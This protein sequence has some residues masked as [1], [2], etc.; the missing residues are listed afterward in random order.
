MSFTWR[1]SGQG[2]RSS[3]QA[4]ASQS[5]M[6]TASEAGPVVPGPE[7]AASGEVRQV[8]LTCGAVRATGLDAM[9]LP[10]L[11]RLGSDRSRTHAPP[12][13]GSPDFGLTIPIAVV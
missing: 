2:S 10:R 8:H 7:H 1:A 3:P 12:P 4:T 11:H 6:R 13:T 9:A 5:V